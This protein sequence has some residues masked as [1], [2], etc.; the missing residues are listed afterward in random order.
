[1]RAVRPRPVLPAT[2]A[3]L[4]AIVAIAIQARADDE[5]PTAAQELA[6]PLRA[7]DA[8]PLP[9]PATDALFEELS[10]GAGRS[11]D[12]VVRVLREL[13][14]PIGACAL[15]MRGKALRVVFVIGA[16]GAVVA[17]VAPG[18]ESENGA[19][20]CVLA[21]LADARFPP[22]T[23]PQTVQARIRWGPPIMGSLDREV[24]RRI[25]H[26]HAAQIRWCYESALA[27]SPAIHGRLKM[28]WVV[29]GEGRITRVDVERD[30]IE[31]DADGKVAACLTKKIKTW[32]FPKPK[33]GGIVIVTYPFVFNYAMP[34]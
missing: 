2:F 23:Q 17:S 32:I 33:G 10:V 14:E 16:D 6:S 34:P 29:G 5:H 7:P 4:V 20:T 24:V 12:V 28:K 3:T 8:V 15:A 30:E 31:G 27:A 9:Q 1:M 18:D 19:A 22:A 26:D 13:E 21:A 25:V 11:R